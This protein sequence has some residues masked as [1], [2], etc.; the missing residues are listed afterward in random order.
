MDRARS[1]EE[2]ELY[3]CRT[4]T[5]ATLFDEDPIQIKPRERKVT[6]MLRSYRYAADNFGSAI[7]AMV[8]HRIASTREDFETGEEASMEAFASVIDDMTLSSREERV[9]E[10][11]NDL[12][13]TEAEKARAW[14]YSML[15]MAASVKEERR[16]E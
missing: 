8:A 13:P 10:F 6:S 11:L 16:D 1:T 7:S 15:R 12:P 3:G 14:W 4:D 9:M 5:W 2:L